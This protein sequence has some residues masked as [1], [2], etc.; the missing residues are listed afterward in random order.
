MKS[1][2]NAQGGLTQNSGS[3]KTSLEQALSEVAVL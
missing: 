3:Q 2:E 1:V